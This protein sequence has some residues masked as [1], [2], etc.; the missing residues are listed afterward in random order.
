MDLS[1]RRLYQISLACEWSSSQV[2]EALGVSQ[3]TVQR[4]WKEERLSPPQPSEAL[5]RERLNFLYSKQERNLTLDDLGK[6][7]LWSR[8]TVANY[9]KKAELLSKQWRE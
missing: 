2:A 7:S 9:V 1:R 3:R 8:R 4:A 6:I 5:N